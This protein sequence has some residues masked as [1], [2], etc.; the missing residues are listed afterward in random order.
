MIGRLAVVV[1]VFSWLPDCKG[2]GE[3]GGSVQK[4]ITPSPTSQPEDYAELRGDVYQRQR[5]QAVLA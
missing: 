5:W 3:P 1:L 4:F 2:E